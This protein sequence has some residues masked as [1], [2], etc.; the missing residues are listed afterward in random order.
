M[1]Q[2]LYYTA[3]FLQSKQYKPAHDKA[4]NKTCAT[5]LGSDQPAHPRSLISF[6]GSHVPS[7]AS[8]LFKEELTKI[9][10]Y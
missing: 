6:R 10:R 7:S 2:G 4:Y 3:L 5:T 9:L 8:R 1:C